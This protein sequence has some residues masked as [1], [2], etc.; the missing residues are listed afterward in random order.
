MTGMGTV[1]VH[2]LT[3]TNEAAPRASW[4]YRT[5]NE[6]AVVA[7][8]VI[9]MAVRLS[10]HMRMVWQIT[11]FSETGWVLAVV[12]PAV[13]ATCRPCGRSAPQLGRR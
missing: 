8:L 7:Q 12:R 11:W 13:A 3:S 10:S 1:A 2:K 5:R 9:D 6:K 4:V